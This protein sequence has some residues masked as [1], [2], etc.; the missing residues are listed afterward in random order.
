MNVRLFILTFVS[1]FSLRAQVADLVIFSC[2]RPLQLYALLESIEKHVKGVGEATVIYRTTH[3]AYKGGYDL[4][5]KHFSRFKFVHQGEHPHKDFKPLTLQ[6][7]FDSTSP[8]VIFAVDDI[9]VKDEVDLSHCIELLERTQAYGFY[10]RAGDHLN[11]CY[12]KNQDQRLPAL[13]NVQEDVFS[14]IFS[15]GEHDWGYPNTI[16][17]TLYRKKDIEGAFRAIDYRTPR[18]LESCWATLAAPIMQRFGLCYKNSKIVNVLLSG[19]P[20]ENDNENGKVGEDI[21]LA[22]FLEG[23]KL[24]INEFYRIK[25]PSVRIEYA[26]TFC[27][28]EVEEKHMI[29]V[30]AS[31]KNAEWYKWNLDSVFNQNYKNWHMIY[32]DDCSPDGTGE[33]VKAYVKECGFE[34]KVTVIC[35]KMR[36][37]AMANLHTAIHMCAPTDIVV[38]LDGDDRLSFP[39]VLNTVNC[40]YAT[41]EVWITYGQYQEY[42]SGDIGFCR[43]YPREIVEN[44][45]FRYFTDGPS[46]L[47]TFYAGLFHKIKL[48]DLFY[49]GDFFPMTYDLAM[50]F[51]MLEMAGNHFMFCP[52][53]L[54]D[55][56]TTNPISDHRVSWDLQR[57]CDR[58]IRSR[59]RYERIE[60]P[61]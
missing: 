60:S 46:H 44:N 32:V 30:T 33:L 61:F 11:F 36:R 57:H 43:D 48:A 19:S 1:V 23:Y 35:N 42:P 16:D 49:E 58:V 7:T 12:T 25:T 40:M 39:N 45:T 28:R 37:K 26:P 29:I 9:I 22:L 52:I 34:D 13:R 14:W 20:V 41:G 5:A 53:P 8:Y 31:Y 56:N 54:L 3:V 17:M 4:V 27:K 6:A 10:L 24:D 59:A 18:S 2:D 50:M 21:L 51:P 15:R 38:I 55:Y 47:R